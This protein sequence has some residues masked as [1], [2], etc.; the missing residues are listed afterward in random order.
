MSS[1]VALNIEPDEAVEEEIDDTKEIQIEEAL[2][3]YQNALKL[4]SQGPQFYPQAAE[5]YDALLKSE[6]FKY[7]ESISDFKRP[8]LQDS[9]NEPLPSELRGYDAAIDSAEA[10]GESDINDSTSSTL[11]QTIYLSYKNHGQF[12]LDSLQS[13]LQN[14]SE[15]PEAARDSTANTTE[16]ARAALTSFA[17]ALE[18]DDTDLN[19]W[20]QSSRLSGALQSYRLV[21][22]CLESVLADDENRLEVRTEQ[23][24][25]EETI[26]E[27]R[28]RSAL[29]SLNDR[30]AVSQVP[31][32]RPKK[33]L[34][35][36]LQRQADP[37]PYLPVLPENLED[38]NPSRKS[39][40][41]K[42]T[43]HVIKP[44]SPTWDAVG[45]E[46]LQ[47]FEDDDDIHIGPGS[48]IEVQLPAITSLE[49]EETEPKDAQQP[50]TSPKPQNEE[51]QSTEQ[52]D[53]IMSDN[54]PPFVKSEEPEQAGEPAA[55]G[56][57][58]P[59][60]GQTE[61]PKTELQDDQQVQQPEDAN[62][63]EEAAADDLDSKSN[64]YRKRSSASAA[65]D[66]HAENQRAKSRRTRA[67]ESNVD[68]SMQTDEI[69]FDQ[70]KY[71]EDRLEMYIHAD[72]CLFEA[73]GAFLSK[74]GV[75][76]LGTV[77][78]LRK[79]MSL[80]SSTDSPVDSTESI[81]SLLSQDLGS[82]V[83]NWDD[84]K[85]KALSDSDNFSNLH[86]IRSL[87]KSGLAIFLEHSKK[88]GRKSGVTNVFSGREELPT[89]LKSINDGWASLD[90]VAFSW[91]KGLLMP[92]FGKF[93]V[94][95][96]ACSDKDWCAME[97]TY[98]SSQWHES[99]KETVLQMLQ[100][101]DEYVYNRLSERVD[102]L[103][104]QILH[105]SSDSTFKYRMGHFSELEMIQAIFELHLDIYASV[106]SPNSE[107][108]QGAR[109]KEY[110][111]LTRW[112]VLAR[113]SLGYFVDYST[114]GE[115]QN[116]TLL[117]HLWASTFHSNMA[118]DVQREHILL[119]LQDLKHIFDRLGNPVVTL[120]NNAAMPE[121]SSE[122]IDQ[123]VSKLKSMGFFIKI[124][125]PESE[126]PVDMIETIEPLLEPSSIE[127][128]ENGTASSESHDSANPASDFEEMA[129]FLDRGD[130]TLRLFLWRRL[131]EAYRAIDYP[132]KVTSCYLRS[133]ETII[134][135]LWSALY[136]EQSSDDRYHTLLR[137]LKSLDTILSKL[138][139]QALRDSDKAYECLDMEHLKSSMSAVARLLK[140]L[141]SFTLY[142]DSVRVGRV[143]APEFR[144]S[145]AKSLEGFRERLREME[146][147]CW[148]LQYTLMKEAIAQNKE[149]FAAPNEDR[150]GYL[151]AVHYALGIRKMC[152]RSHKEF[153]RLLKSE[154][155]TIETKE[156]LDL[157]ICQVFYDLHGYRLINSDLITDHGCTSERIDRATAIMMID[158]V[159]RQAMKVN[160]KDLSKSDLKSTI[161]KM[162]QA[163]GNSKSSA[164]LTF[165]KRIFSAYLKSPINP[166]EVFRAARGV[167]DLP[168][169]PV[170][171]ESALI[172]Q[173]GWFFLLGYS[174]LAKFRS[175]K[176]L[177]P[178]GTTELD[179]GVSYFRQDIEN[180]SG[181]WETWYRLAQTYDSK[182]EEDITWSAEKINNNQTELA[183]LQRNAIHCYAMALSMAN[184]TAEPTTETRATLSELYTDFGI[185]MYSS[186][187]EP[188]SMGAFDISGFA[189]HFS[190]EES[191]QMYKKEPFREMRLY[192]VWNFAS[193]LLKRAIVD[194]PRNWV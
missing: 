125:S 136:A 55:D 101:A 74:I 32:K 77:E 63:R 83:S 79:H 109:L 65:N 118:Q 60:D 86:D 29:Q 96:G 108:D 146:V 180:R 11:L 9:E 64:G 30:L 46:I 53:V 88:S 34:I 161:D 186:S 160:I 150:I 43:R 181:R 12:L 103:D 173:K 52:P 135:E 54:Q 20:R 51:D 184:R 139:S 179:E 165:N 134:T 174:A 26:A 137:W 58:S 50:D 121:L 171:T 164:A 68:P 187:R 10:I 114:M 104:Y 115:N 111:R 133:I 21:R 169:T 95:D 177:T 76:E 13:L 155:H 23:L 97:S 159:M 28:L 4:H 6:I 81:E 126:D 92:A 91:L 191:Q 62:Q 78:Y 119:C 149:L 67:R 100:L 140:L 85:V 175:Q 84:Q 116:N 124:F 127:Y 178:V 145:L 93:S 192:S 157:E 190:N 42:A 40:A 8:A 89:C 110:D 90:E 122:A 167:E 176:R 105:Q 70:S 113:N 106:N 183:T 72:E 166:T 154:F 41:L 170:A 94:Q 193:H 3:L 162:Q 57:T 82:I 16:G 48:S 66:E 75:E 189:R 61:E 18:R 38:M 131:Q 15:Q 36:F 112:S 35:K 152:R 27:E 45:E 98:T 143:P 49:P 144:G 102:A 33:A 14:V 123:E 194:K 148:I 142:E 87:G 80:V 31:V 138:V 130:A 59:G 24:G 71:Y 73:T 163:I 185:R 129:S 99:L 69:T 132:P 107:F 37:Y 17:E 44:S 25:L 168:L 22:Y 172:A 141:H 156:D 56:Q 128:T 19:L 1:W 188:L 117:R 2:K 39:L 5:A 151:R 7:P 47:L 120:N 147:R 153:L 158:F 182:L